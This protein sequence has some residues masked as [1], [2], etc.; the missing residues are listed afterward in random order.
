MKKLV[1]RTVY[2]GSMV[3]LHESCIRDTAQILQ[4]LMDI[5]D[6]ARFMVG[7][8]VGISSAMLSVE[9]SV[10]EEVNVMEAINLAERNKADIKHNGICGCYVCQRVFLGKEI[11]EYIENNAGSGELSAVCP[12]CNTVGVVPNCT[13]ADWLARAHEYLITSAHSYDPMLE[14][15]KPVDK[16]ILTDMDIAN[17][18]DLL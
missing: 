3:E 15:E 1:K 13:D 14:D 16:A 5:D 11:T 10:E 6:N 18:I 9:Y 7:K 2:L 4:K 8:N 17:V 12:Y